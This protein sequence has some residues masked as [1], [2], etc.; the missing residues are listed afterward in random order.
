MALIYFGNGSSLQS[1]ERN[2]TLI[3]FKNVTFQQSNNPIPVSAADRF[4]II[5]NDFIIHVNGNNPSPFDFS[6]SESGTS[7][8]IAPGPY[9]VTETKPTTNFFSAIFSKDC[10]GEINDGDTKTCMVTNKFH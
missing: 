10:N 8:S 9:A 7:V 3:V 6:G 2:A 5:A 1:S 4:E